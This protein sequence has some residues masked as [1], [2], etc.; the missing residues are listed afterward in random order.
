[1]QNGTQGGSRKQTPERRKAQILVQLKWTKS[2]KWAEH[3][4][5]NRGLLFIACLIFSCSCSWYIATTGEEENVLLKRL[6]SFEGKLRL[7]LIVEPPNEPS[8]PG[9]EL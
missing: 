5:L 1:M 3:C 9:Y 4:P 7:K 2:W 6:G 8:L